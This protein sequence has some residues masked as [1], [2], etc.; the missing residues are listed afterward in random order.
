MNTISVYGRVASDV[1]LKD[2]SGRKVA[3]FRVAAQNKR[4]DPNT[5]E[6]GTNFYSV[7]AWG[8]MGENAAKFLKKGNRTTVSGELIIRPYVGNDGTQRQAIEIDANSIDFVETKAESEAKATA[9]AATA[10]TPAPADPAN[11]FTQVE[12]DE[13]PF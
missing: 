6:Y 1:T 3:E 12:T 9:P 8:P 5:R 13:L 2:V 4:K 11:G 10:P 7:S